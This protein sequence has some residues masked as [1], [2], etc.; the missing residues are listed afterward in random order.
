MVEALG[1]VVK[2]LLDTF[3]SG[4]GWES[5]LNINK[6]KQ[7]ILETLSCS[8]CGKGFS[9]KKF[10][11]NHVNKVHIEDNNSTPTT[12]KCKFCSEE[13]LNEETQ[14]MNHMKIHA[15]TFPLCDVCAEIC[16]D[17]YQKK[18]HQKKCMDRSRRFHDRV[19]RTPGPK[20]SR[21]TDISDIDVNCPKCNFVTNNSDEFRRHMRD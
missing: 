8:P 20:R 15:Q 2:T 11:K 19:Y 9:A 21:P 1:K 12:T 14:I 10:L 5:T 4:K 7:T 18:K 16:R 6:E 3:I 13:I 17:E